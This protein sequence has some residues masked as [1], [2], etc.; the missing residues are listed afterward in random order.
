MHNQTPVCQ[1]KTDGGKKCHLS[2]ITQPE[3]QNHPFI[4]SSTSGLVTYSEVYSIYWYLSGLEV[5]RSLFVDLTRCQTSP[6]LSVFE[7]QL[8]ALSS[9]VS[10][11]FV[12]I[13]GLFAHF[14]YKLVVFKRL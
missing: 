6:Y 14:T 11:H 3:H 13:E 2:L 10:A 12:Q 8:D 1:I 5:N 9:P 4:L 7:L